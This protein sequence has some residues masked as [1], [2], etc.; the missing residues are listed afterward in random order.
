MAIRKIARMGNPVLRQ[1]A[2]ALTPD[3]ILSGAIRQ[4]VVDMRETMVEYEGVGIAA[5]QI[6]ESLQ[7]ALIEVETEGPNGCVQVSY[8]VFNPR[9]TV[10]DETLLGHWEGCLSV[11]DLRGYVERPAKVRIDYLDG[12]AKPQSLVAEGFSAT[13]FQHEL[14]HLDGVLYVDRLKSPEHFSFVKEFNRYQG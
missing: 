10:L 14:D 8:T 12:E 7:I 11:P 1:R 4:L 9:V 6:H 3:E 13:V 2:R 5:P